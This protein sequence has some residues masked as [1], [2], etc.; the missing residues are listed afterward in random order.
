MTAIYSN[1]DLDMVKAAIKLFLDYFEAAMLM[2][3]TLSFWFLEASSYLILMN[4]WSA[5]LSANAV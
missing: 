2:F 3:W 4:G 1:L 5:K